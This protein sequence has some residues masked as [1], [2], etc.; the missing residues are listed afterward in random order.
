M[1]E[2]VQLGVT[3]RKAFFPLE[4]NPDVFNEVLHGLGVSRA[5]AFQDVL[6]IDEPDVL[7]MTGRPVLALVFV[8]PGTPMYKSQKQEDEDRRPT[9]M[10]KGEGEDVVWYKQTIYN[11][12]GLYGI[13]HAISNGPV[14]QY[15]GECL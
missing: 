1:S 6:S 15:I 9:Y 12:C 2:H 8:L 11:A 5:L 4:S 13:L 7:A 14:R 3:H 10:G